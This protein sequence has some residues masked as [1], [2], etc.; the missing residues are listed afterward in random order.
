M[1]VAIMQPYFFPYIGYFQLINAADEFVI[2]DNIQF[3]KKGWI[4][5]NRIWVNGSDVHI[6]LPLKKD[7]DYLDVCERFLSDS[8][9]ADR[10]KILN[11]INESYRKAPCYKQAIDIVTQVLNSAERNLFK[12]IFN[13]LSIINQYLEIKT[14][15]IISSELNVDHSLKSA[16]KVLAI[17]KARGADEYINPIGGLDLYNKDVFKKNGIELKFLK[18]HE[19]KYEQFS[20]EFVPWLSIIDVMMFNKKEKIS[21]YLKNYYTLI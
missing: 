18:S 6:S 5:R 20:H 1:K 3:T 10:V 12:F 17:C 14:P 9:E 4:N 13:S 2:Y 19:V 16:D 15:F 8:W 7:S 11:R 21:E